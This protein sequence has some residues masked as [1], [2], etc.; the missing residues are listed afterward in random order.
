MLLAPLVDTPDTAIFMI[1]G[2]IVFISLPILF[3]LS[4]IYRYRNLKRDE[5]LLE[6]LKDDEKKP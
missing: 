2:Y 3:I 4:L 1:V 6:Q 5:E